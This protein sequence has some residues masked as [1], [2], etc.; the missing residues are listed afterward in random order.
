MSFNSICLNKRLLLTMAV[1]LHLF[2]LIL[3][4]GIAAD[5]GSLLPDCG[6]CHP[7]WA[8][9]DQNPE[10]FLP[11]ADIKDP[12]MCIKCH[13]DEVLR[14][15]F[16]IP[17][18]PFIL[19]YEESI[20]GKDSSITCLDCH[21]TCTHGFQGGPPLASLRTKVIVAGTC[22]KCHSE[23]LEAYQESAHGLAI[24]NHILDA[25][26][27][28]DCHGE[29]S[30][31]SPSNNDSPVS[32]Q[33]IPL[34]CGSCHEGEKLAFRYGFSGRRLS[35][36]RQSY[37][38]MASRLGEENV[39]NCTSCHK[40]HDI[41]PPSDTRSAVHPEN[42]TETCGQCHRGASAEFINSKIHIQVSPESARGA[43][44]VRQFYIYFIG[45]LMI[46]FLGYVFLDITHRI[47]RAR[48]KPEKEKGSV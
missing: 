21:Q 20:H 41:Y 24:K 15:N 28:T 37:H 5:V 1:C 11:E 33:N 23:E 9:S 39:A 16:N 42:L 22:G 31:Q 2:L 40:Y 47:R 6:T 29:H 34:T 18:V 25:P 3:V 38:G 44:Y 48:Q 4:H 8:A 43:W 30:I 14:E 26:V 13:T 27:C 19:S 46:M 7:D 12:A 36:Y 17:P 32:F 45:I 10:S 35:T